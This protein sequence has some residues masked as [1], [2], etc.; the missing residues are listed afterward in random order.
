MRWG[1]RMAW[2][3][4][5]LAA[6]AACAGV[7]A[8]VKTAQAETPLPL[9]SAWLDAKVNEAG[10]HCEK[11]AEQRDGKRLLV[12]CGPAGVWEIALDE[13]TPRLVRSHGGFAGD[14]VGFFTEPDGR[15]WVKV[16]VLEARPFAAG[17]TQGAVR[18]PDSSFPAS[19]SAPVPATTPTPTSPALGI[20]TSAPPAP[21]PATAAGKRVGRVTRSTPGEVVISLGSTDGVGRGDHIEL[22][23]EHPEDAADGEIALSREVVAVGIVSNVSERSAKVRLGLN[24][25][26]PVG[27]QATQSPSSLTSSLSAPPRVSDLWTLELMARPFAALGELGGGVLLSGAFGRRF[28][29]L[30]LQAVVDPLGLGDVQDK[31]HVTAANAAVIASYDSQ[32]F[33]MGLGLGAQTVNDSDFLLPPGSGLAVLQLIRLGAQDGLNISARTNVVLF[34]SEFRFGGM[35]ASGQI[36]VTRG[37]WLLLNGGGGN[38][39]YGYGELG[40]RV[41]LTDNGLAGSKFLTVTA[42]GAAVFRSATCDSFNPC[43][44]AVTY[45]GPMAGV[46][47][48][49]RF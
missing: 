20:P 19:S 34:H 2:W 46:G 40:L 10:Q 9:S 15:L 7:L 49:M 44:Q 36:P 13:P 28:G 22:V 41:L 5:K 27:A 23:V 38:I 43:D 42:G 29:H 48:E 11:H 25:S 8:L 32:Y 18:F 3:S 6:L 17:G 12:A 37:Y 33:E 35:V 16:Q 30:H 39:G 31:R 24:E 4:K 47:Y 26:V 45:G 21:A 1:F 14:V